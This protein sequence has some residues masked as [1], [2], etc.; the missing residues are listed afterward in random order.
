M[1]ISKVNTEM[2]KEQEQS[3]KKLYLSTRLA[4]VIP[5]AI[6]PHNSEK[7]F[8]FFSALASDNLT[9]NG[10]QTLTFTFDN[11]VKLDPEFANHVIGRL[12]LNP[13]NQ[14]CL[15]IWPSPTRIKD[16]TRPPMKHE[17]LFENVQDFSF[18]FFLPPSR[19][20]KL[21]LSNN[22][23]TI[24]ESEFL[25]IESLGEWKQEWLEEYGELPPLIKM[26]LTLADTNKNKENPETIVLVYPLPL[27]RFIIVYQ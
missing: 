22:K 26:T 18:E 5:K 8:F 4:T 9:K 27:S 14:L 15:A 16:T 13:K 3:F 17:I 7:D 23:Q 21:I 11:G 12:Y 24:K 20:R 10:T 6:S 25:K 2:E 1:Q 19:D